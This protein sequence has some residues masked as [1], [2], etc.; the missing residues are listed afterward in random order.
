MATPRTNRAATERSKTT[1]KKTWTPPSMLDAPDAPPGFK[2][3]WIRESAAGQDDKSNMS[4][5]LREGFELVRAEDYPDFPAP[6]IDNGAHA[7]I[8]GVGG[9]VLAKIPV[10]IA[11]SRNDYYQQQAEDMVQAA[12]SDL[13]RESNSSMPISSPD[14]RTNVTFGNPENKSSEDS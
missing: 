13:M 1:R 9:L 11:E 7:G 10:E 6:T 4:K 5:R 8:I 14:R 12:D 3:R 2:H